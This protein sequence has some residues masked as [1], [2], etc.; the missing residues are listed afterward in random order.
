MQRIAIAVHGGAGPDSD[1]IKNNITGYEQGLRAAVESGYAILEKGGTAMQAVEEAV[2]ILEDNPL[3]NAGKG[4]ALNNKGEVEMDASIMNGQ[5]L[6][7]GAVAG[8]KKIKNPITL[9]RFILERTTH[10]LIAGDGALE[11]ARENDI[12]LESDEYFVTEY[13]YK[14]F[15]EESKNESPQQL[16]SKQVHG[17]VGAVALDQN[18]NLA[19]A[20][21]TG[22]TTNSLPGRIGD[23]CLIGAGCYA[24][25]DTCA[26][27]GTGDGEFLISG[28]IAHS[29]SSVIEYTKCSI[30]QACDYIIHEKNKNS[31]GDMGVISINAAGEFGIAFN[32]ERMHRAWMSSEIPLQVKVY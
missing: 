32:S 16:L 5:S 20:T 9:A 26:I 2:R 19:A 13:Q 24:N 29:V 10:V 8:V 15:E 3:F 21:S 6:K 22:G 28:V 1:Y 27:S 30:Q 7:A 25:N 17:T 23:S 18:G 11:L 31:K 14:T 12:Q 4:S